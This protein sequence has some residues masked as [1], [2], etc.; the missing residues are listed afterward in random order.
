MTP[1]PTRRRARQIAFCLGLGA[2]SYLLYT[3]ARTRVLLAQGRSIEAHSA[4]F[5][6]DYF[7]GD[8][9]APTLNYL[10]LGD[11]TAAG[12]GAQ[13]LAETYPHR[14]AQTLAARGFRVH[15]RNVAI[16][17]ARARDVM[18]QLPALQTFAPAVITLSVGANDATHFT[19][20]ADFEREMKTII[21]ALER[22]SARAVWVAN[23]PDMFLA[24]ALPLPLA[25]A[26][27]RRARAQNATLET[28]VSRARIVDLYG[29]GKLDARQNPAL[30]AA[31]RF[32]P[33]NL[34]YAKWAA[35]FA[36]LRFGP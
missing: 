30:Y 10:A 2:I 6:R 24:P 19:A 15:V 1:S 25:W 26:M 31:D 9:Q 22:S 12:W 16:G 14:I 8:A 35:L 27:A 28:L 20:P 3:A 34:G 32:H 17:G 7:V 29:R 18:E 13:T 5:A 11:S 33:S 23:T 36:Q 21:A 4:S